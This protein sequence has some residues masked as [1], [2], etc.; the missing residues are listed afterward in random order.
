MVAA[1]SGSATVAGVAKPD[2]VANGVSVLGVLPPGSLVA[3]ANPASH[4]GGAMWR[5][6]G[7]SPAAA[8]TSG[9]VALLLERQP[10][11]SPAE[12]KALL[13]ASARQLPGSRDGAGLLRVA[14]GVAAGADEPTAGPGSGD[15]TGEGA[16]DASS[17]S[18]SSWSASSWS[19]S[20]WSASSWSAS[21]WSAS[22]WSGAQP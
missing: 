19:A 10:K 22:S 1:F 18:A 20:S 6:S 11:A 15:P 17:W 7:T 13:R 21:S 3:E 5:G 8:V 4:V 2:V 9:V 14:F 12:V 16:F